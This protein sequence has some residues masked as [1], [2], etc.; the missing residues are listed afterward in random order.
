MR[1]GVINVCIG[2]VMLLSFN[3]MAHLPIGIQLEYILD[4]ILK[5]NERISCCR[6]P[7]SVEHIVA[8]S[9]CVLSSGRTKDQR[10]I[11]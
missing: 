3:K 10:H 8:D 1:D 2:H 11:I 6:K 5:Q 9:L 4:P 7:I